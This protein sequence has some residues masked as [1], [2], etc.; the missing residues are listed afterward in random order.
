MRKSDRGEFAGIPEGAL[1]DIASQLLRE[2]SAEARGEVIE[3]ISRPGRVPPGLPLTADWVAEARRMRREAQAW[4]DRDA[5]NDER[6][7]LDFYNRVYGPTPE[8]RA[9]NAVYL[10]SRHRTIKEWNADFEEAMEQLKRTGV[11]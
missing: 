5:A 8:A 2:T 7:R 11:L 4:R 10:G 3:Y 1:L 9:L 6:L